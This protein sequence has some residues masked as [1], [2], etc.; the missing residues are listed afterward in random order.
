[1]SAQ[2]VKD[3]IRFARDAATMAGC[4]A[5]AELDRLQ[6]ELADTEGEVT[7]RMEGAMVGGRPALRILI[8]ANPTLICQACLTPYVHIL[9]GEGVIYL[10]R[11]DAE[12]ERWEHDDPL[13][14]VIVSEEHMDVRTLIED[15]LLLSLPVVPRHEDEDCVRHDDSLGEH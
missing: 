2:T 9:H 6:D 5:L 4:Y 3:P 7:W 1:M 14:D 8:E 10:A 12:L 15:E 13:L 11:N